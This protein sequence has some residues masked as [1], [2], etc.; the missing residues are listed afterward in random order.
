MFRASNPNHESKHEAE[1]GNIAILKELKLFFINNKHQ[2]SE[3]Q[4]CER[5]K[6][7]LKAHN[8]ELVYDVEERVHK[9]WINDEPL[10]PQSTIQ[11]LT[12]IIESLDALNPQS[13]D[14]SSNSSAALSL[15]N[16][17][18][19]AH[20][21]EGSAIAIGGSI[22]AK[23][24]YLGVDTVINKPVYI[25]YASALD[26]SAL[27][28]KETQA[29]TQL[30]ASYST[31]EYTTIP[32][33]FGPPLKLE[34]Q[35]INLQ[36]LCTDLKTKKIEEDKESQD[37]TKTK[38]DEKYKDVRMASVEDLFGD[39][40][41][42]KAES[43][44]KPIR[45][46]F[47]NQVLEAKDT[48]EVP[49]LLLVQG[50]AGIGKTTFV[51]YV[52]H[53]WSKG[54]LYRNY[55]WVFTLTLRKLRLLAHI[56]ELSLPEWIRLSQFSDWEQKE[57]DELWKHRIDSAIRQNKAL[58]ILDGYDETPENHPCQS[59]LKSLLM[60]GRKYSSISLLITTRPCGAQEITE[61]RRNLE[62]IGFTDDNINQYIQT[63]F[64]KAPDKALVN[65]L[66][67]T[68]RK[69]PVIWAN[70]HIP[71]NLNLL[72]GIMEETIQK[73]QVEGLTQGL[74]QLSSMTRLYQVM[75]KKLYEW[76]HSRHDTGSLKVGRQL[77]RAQTDFI[78][79][80]QK[81]RLFLAQLAFQSF[82]TE[83]IIISLQVIG[84]VLQA[85]VD[86]EV[87]QGSQRSIQQEKER[88]AEEFF[89][90]VCRL[91]L[92]KPVLDKS[93]FR[94]TQQ[95]YEFLHLTF[96]EYYVAIYLAEGLGSEKS[97][98]RNQ[99]EKTILREK[100]NPRWQIVW[101]FIAGLLRE[102]VSVYEV[103]LQQLQGNQ[104]A[105][106][107]LTQDILEHYQLG[108]LTRCLD[109]GIEL[110]NRNVIES[111]VK[112]I[113]NNFLNLYQIA[114]HLKNN[115]TT[116][117]V[118]DLELVQS[119]F[120]SACRISLN[121]CIREQQDLYALVSEVSESEDKYFLL[122]W[123]SCIRIVTPRVLS[124]LVCL[125][126]DMN[127]DVCCAAI[128]AVGVLGATAAIP[129]IL[130][131][132]VLLLTDEKRGV[133]S[134]T[135]K[136]VSK[137][138]AA[139]ATPKILDALVRLF[140]NRNEGKYAAQ[141]VNKLGA[142][143]IPQVQK[144]LMA[145]F[146]EDEEYT[147]YLVGEVTNH[148]IGLV[149]AL[150]SAVATPEILATLRGVI[151]NW[152]V[153]ARCNA[154][155]AVGE[156]GSIAVTSEIL[157][158]LE[159]M[160]GEIDHD[161]R[162]TAGLNHDVRNCAGRVLK[163]LGATAITSEILDRL[164]GLLMHHDCDVRADTAWTVCQLGS[165]AATP[166]ILKALMELLGDEIH[167]VRDN[168]GRAL[169]ELGATAITSEILDTLAG[170]L[171]HDDCCV[172]AD[173]ANTVGHLL[174]HYRDGVS[175]TAA[176]PSAVVATPKILDVLTR[177]LADKERG[178]C[179]SAAYAVGR[180]GAIAATPK[181]LDALTRLLKEETRRGV[182]TNFASSALGNL[183]I[184]ATAMPRVL[185]SLV[186]LLTGNYS[187]SV[188]CN[189]TDAVTALGSAA[190]TPKILDALEGLLVHESSYVRSLAATTVSALG[191]AAGTPQILKALT[192]LLKEK[193]NVFHDAARTV[194][195]LGAAAATSEIL[196]LL[197]ELLADTSTS[198]YARSSAAKA[199]SKLGAAATT[200]KILST[201]VRLLKDKDWEVRRCALDAAVG[202]GAATPKL[203]D[204]LALLLVDKDK[205]VR[206]FAVEA[207]GKLSAA[208]PEFLRW[209]LDIVSVEDSNSILHIFE[210]HIGSLF[211]HMPSICAENANHPHL[212]AF[213]SYTLAAAYLN[214]HISC[215]I[216]F[217]KEGEP[218]GY[219]LRGFIVKS[220][221]C[222][223]MT[224]VQAQGLRHLFSLVIEQLSE[225]G[226]LDI[227]ELEKHLL[228]WT[229]AQSSLSNRQCSAEECGNVRMHLPENLE[230]TSEQKGSAMLTQ[231]QQ[232]SRSI[233]ELRANENH[234]RVKDRC[235][236]S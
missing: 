75:E 91:G 154:L 101:W 74:A 72:C 146:A 53:Q 104:C 39:K 80:Y 110:H 122:E 171:M 127:K 203:L 64:S 176:W 132:L 186:E 71:L 55:A 179:Q 153:S 35:Y 22:N 229:I 87:T 99:V 105:G 57:F 118:K 58:L 233:S 27:N 200:P 160:L 230:D 16:T 142:A 195:A 56:Q 234:G 207:A 201:F 33:I 81:E 216:D 163:K 45:E 213:V 218:A 60:A 236:L 235:R 26:E 232:S 5:Y 159:S 69:Q 199:L 194:G 108:L 62:I 223:L 103:Y 100:Y 131:A 189:A 50:R 83:R 134:D 97:A 151:C 117:N 169:K 67:E 49:R 183:S 144:A 4:D 44:F 228:E 41:V 17:V 70:A 150:G 20:A 46:L 172:R 167:D 224:E 225:T 42:I 164:A 205:D 227:A 102:N 37:L 180:L 128:K 231:Y 47:G 89:D 78:K 184:S 61:K 133:R 170:L 19:K 1:L 152:D 209:L 168:A 185:D 113:Q 107:M 187:V 130:D 115:N 36:I 125:L 208:T 84:E 141:A 73:T 92:I 82:E 3:S 48:D 9:V 106:Q 18:I 220:G 65:T 149:T 136:M 140:A 181:I 198:S 182:D 123:I 188:R 161:E 90:E 23:K 193:S 11:T 28:A 68:L 86:K 156:L 126:G 21:K 63:Y 129:Q 13:V 147:S 178:V 206:S 177:L 95:D 85:Y 77:I 66:T 222:F 158:Y 94:Q 2:G 162:H 96:Q 124:M 40:R 196:D 226:R 204:A 120:F 214:S 14:G 12:A 145:L 190:A 197:T 202:L 31:P 111:I 10:E 29:V 25:N 192:G 166:K 211:R 24:A 34:G 175:D 116:F 219:Y 148:T 215:Q 157:N 165:V 38:G 30:K 52:A 217:D 143:A 138:G 43:L 212:L 173:T 51:R 7:G 139:A 59:I 8:A 135:V 15:G 137:L 114:K 109:E 155:W 98:I 88:L 76:S 210:M 221:Y 174:T 121:F 93:G 112:K 32:G 54:Q 6:N 119:F 79:H 191:T